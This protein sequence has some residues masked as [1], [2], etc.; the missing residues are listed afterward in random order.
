MWLPSKGLARLFVAT[1][2]VLTTIALGLGRQCSRNSGDRRVVS[3]RYQ[4][5]N[6]YLFGVCHS[7]FFMLDVEANKIERFPLAD[8]HL[9]KFAG[10]SPWQDR[11]GR[12]HLAGL[13]M[14]RSRPDKD[15]TNGLARYALPSREV[16]DRVEMDVIPASPPCW[17]PDTSA[18]ILFAGTDG[19]LY[20]FS[21]EDPRNPNSA[22]D[23]KRSPLPLIW[24]SQPPAGLM[25]VSAPT[26]PSDPRLEGKIIVAVTIAEGPLIQ[27]VLRRASQ[28]QLWWLQLSRD[29]SAI[30]AGAP[31][32]SK[33]AANSAERMVVE[34]L[35]VIATLSDGRIV[36]AYLA[37]GESE[38]THR[39]RLAPLMIQGSSNLPSVDEATA[40]ECSGRFL[41][42][43]PAFSGDG[44]WVYGVS[45]PSQ[46]PVRIER[47]SVAE[48][49]AGNPT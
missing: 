43:P 12:T 32:I 48:V 20:R 40:V 5:V 23:D 44:L 22:A 46:D 9:L 16:L 4:P 18:R 17:F 25:R 35:P 36:L 13:W 47:F 31:L 2:V 11:W 8:S 24:Q 1:A 49:L 42:S 41:L 45:Q 19:R 27:P 26:W 37:C 30:V 7:D 21:F 33:E 14:G 34:D 6:T 29:Y 39:L 38:T 28:T 3:P 15:F 10:C